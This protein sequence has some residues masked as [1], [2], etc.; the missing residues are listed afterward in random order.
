MTR[1]IKLT[2]EYDG[3]NLNGWQIQPR[4]QRTV[5]GLIE[6]ALK[7]ILWEK[8]RLIGSGR[9]DSGVHAIGQVAHFQTRSEKPQIEILKSFFPTI[10][11][12]SSFISLMSSLR[13]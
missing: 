6:K 3:T 8:V 7:V 10:D 5:Q 11:L 2:I 13:G 4:K 1:N 12:I 9:T